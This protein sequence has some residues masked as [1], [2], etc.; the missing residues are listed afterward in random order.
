VKEE[1][2]LVSTA[3]GESE[4]GV[5]SIGFDEEDL[6]KRNI[7]VPKK[8]VSMQE[9]KSSIALDFPT[10]SA[11]FQAKELKEI[12]EHINHNAEPIR[13]PIVSQPLKDMNIDDLENEI[14]EKM[15]LLEAKRIEVAEKMLKEAEEKRLK[16]EEDKKKEEERIKQEEENKKQEEEIMQEETIIEGKLI[17]EIKLNSHED[18]NIKI[19]PVCSKK[20]KR[21]KVKKNGFMLMQSIKCKKCGYENEISLM[22]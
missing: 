10:I 7:W 21:M 15:I 11:D 20:L 17:N 1:L 12:K 22:F 6:H 9:K 5:L 14:K 2:K 8:V 4:K 3:R 16:E 13:E 19:C 18:I